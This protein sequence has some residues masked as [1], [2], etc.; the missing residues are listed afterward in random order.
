M[1]LEIDHIDMPSD[2]GC[3]TWN[4]P[5]LH[6][7]NQQTQLEFLMSFDCQLIS[8][9]LWHH[10][11][12]WQEQMREIPDEC[13]IICLSGGLHFHPRDQATQLVL[14]G[15]VL[16]LPRWLSHRLSFARPDQTTAN[17]LVIHCHWLNQQGDNLFQYLSELIFDLNPT[18][19]VPRL[20]QLHSLWSQ[21]PALGLPYIQQGL[22][23]MFFDAISHGLSFR[24]TT[25]TKDPMII[26]ALTYIRET[27]WEELNVES[28]ARRL[29]VSPGRFRQRFKASLHMPPSK[30][31]ASRR[32]EYGAQLLQQDTRSLMAIAH[33][34]GFSSVTHFHAA[35]KQRFQCTPE[36][37]RNR[38]VW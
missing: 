4:C 5:P 21:R 14:P 25:G 23:H 31:I 29:Q 16:C 3:R 6:D 22:S 28:I 35:F 33:D 27:P 15:Q 34:I 9:A 11:P 2:I 37:W 30:Y 12:Q 24:P 8:S 36:E 19:W 32:L 10:G 18:G 20:L 38:T 26:Q 7:L 13:L 17:M 1:T